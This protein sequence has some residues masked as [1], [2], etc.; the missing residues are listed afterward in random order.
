MGAAVQSVLLIRGAFLRKFG[1]KRKAK[2]FVFG[3]NQLE[4]TLKHSQTMAK[5]LNKIRET[6]PKP[7][8]KRFG[9]AGGLIGEAVLLG[10]A[11]L[12]EQQK[13][14]CFKGAKRKKNT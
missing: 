9:K 8:Q 5:H 11:Q 1:A 12:G 14:G 10:Q 13:R 6:P 2:G 4:N 3:G 7:L